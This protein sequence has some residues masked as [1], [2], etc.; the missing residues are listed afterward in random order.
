MTKIQDKFDWMGLSKIAVYILFTIT[1]AAC[2]GAWRLRS[3]IAVQENR[4]THVE[5]QADSTREVLSHLVPREE[6]V[7]KWDDDRRRYDDLMK[8][9]DEIRGDIRDLKGDVRSGAV[10][11]EVR[12]DKP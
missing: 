10:D 11:K 7:A 5:T 3:D 9:L 2:L 12:K 8:R 6:Y 1:G 4:I